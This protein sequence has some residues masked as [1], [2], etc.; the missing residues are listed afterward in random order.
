MKQKIKKIKLLILDVDGVLTDGKIIVDTEG[1]EIKVFDVQD[2][3][4]IVFFQKAGF[5]T[6][7]LTA[8][9]SKAVT[10]RAKDLKIHKVYQ[11]A[12]PKIDGYKKLLKHFKVKDDEACFVADDLT[13]L[14]VLKKVGFAVAVANATPE[15]KRVADY[16]TKKQGGAGAAREVI[17]LILK[18]QGKW[19]SVLEKE[20][21]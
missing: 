11:G 6:A 2:G 19:K 7:I 16:V 9:N 18:S 8:R 10:V 21:R 20:S 5:K 1:R 13:D 12:Y 15:V 3:Y 17:E 4:G 14:A